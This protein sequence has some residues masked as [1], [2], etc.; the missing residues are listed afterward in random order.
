MKYHC[1]LFTYQKKKAF[2]LGRSKICALTLNTLGPNKKVQV[3]W[4][5]LYTYRYGTLIMKTVSWLALYW[6]NDYQS[7]NL[8]WCKM[9]VVYN[10]KAPFVHGYRDTKVINTSGSSRKQW[11]VK[12]VWIKSCFENF[13][14]TKLTEER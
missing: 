7:R 13:Q 9:A 1:T 3:S 14:L 8:K 2:Y 6:G 10:L 12:V 5:F 11:A 4:H